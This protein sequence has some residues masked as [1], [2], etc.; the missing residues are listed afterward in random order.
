MALR[1]WALVISDKDHREAA[2]KAKLDKFQRGTRLAE[3]VTV[4]ES[5][6]IRALFGRRPYHALLQLRAE[7]DGALGETQLIRA[8]EFLEAN[9]SH[10]DGFWG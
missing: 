8:F 9:F 2:V 1:G 6:R 3:G 10:V 7:Q 5:V 4:T